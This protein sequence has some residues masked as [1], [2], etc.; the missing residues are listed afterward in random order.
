M[1]P[2]N[3]M[4]W[5]WY[6][7]GRRGRLCT[8]A[9]HGPT[10]S[11]W[12][13][14]VYVSNFLRQEEMSEILQWEDAKPLWL[15]SSK[16]SWVEGI[17]ILGWRD[18]LKGSRSW[19]HM[20]MNEYVYERICVWTHVCI[21]VWRDLLCERMCVCRPW[22]ERGRVRGCMCVCMCLC[23]CI[24]LELKGVEFIARLFVLSLHE[25]LVPLCFFYVSLEQKAC[26]THDPVSM[27][28]VQ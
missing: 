1:S 18:W 12:E 11:R 15:N 27:S 8:I 20:C 24:D 25:C 23:M 9:C 3:M 5:T 2:N 6:N 21:L 10:N 16:V 14:T 13:D 4:L 28:W 7:F 22:A 19:T 17:I 26:L